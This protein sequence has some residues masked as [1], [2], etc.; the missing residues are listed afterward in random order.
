ML[1]PWNCF[2]HRT[3]ERS[4]TLR[5]VCKRPG[6]GQEALYLRNTS[7]T[8]SFHG[9]PGEKNFKMSLKKLYQQLPNLSSPVVGPLVVG[10]CQHCLLFE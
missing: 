6:K 8:Q 9:P 1:S 7:V 4:S 3:G 5:A 2:V 10:T